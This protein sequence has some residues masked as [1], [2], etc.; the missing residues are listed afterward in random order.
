MCG[1][2]ASRPKPPPEPTRLPT[3]PTQAEYSDVMRSVQKKKKN[4]LIFSSPLNKQ[5]DPTLFQRALL[6]S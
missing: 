1:G 2:K 3:P 4:P 6:G 5:E